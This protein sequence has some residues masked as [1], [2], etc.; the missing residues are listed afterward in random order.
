MF[1][2][3]D[4]NGLGVGVQAVPHLA[5]RPPRPAS[6]GFPSAS[7]TMAWRLGKK[8]AAPEDRSNLLRF[9]RKP[10]AGEGIRTLD[11]NLGKRLREAA[12]A[13]SAAPSS[14]TRRSGQ[15]TRSS[16]AHPLGAC[17]R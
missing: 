7:P 1:D 3:A 12:R 11:P 17:R 15:P 14:I 6:G 8:K 4:P 16:E 2:R 9:F 5:A 13:I 10:G